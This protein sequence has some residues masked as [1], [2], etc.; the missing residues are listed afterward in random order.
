MNSKGYPLLFFVSI[1]LLSACSSTRHTQKYSQKENQEKK[2]PSNSDLVFIEDISNPQIK[3]H[4]SH[5]IKAYSTPESIIE[6]KKATLFQKKYS[7][8]LELIPKEVLYDPPLW[9]FISEWWGT[10]YRY[11]GTSKRGIDCSAFSQRLYMKVF[12]N[13]LPRTAREQYKDTKK[14]K[15]TKNL[16]PGDLVFFKIHSRHITHVGIY[17]QNDKFIS[18]TSSSGVTISDL[19]SPYWQ[20]YYVGGGRPRTK[21]T[22]NNIM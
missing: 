7:K 3:Q 4:S 19:N 21:D 12:G 8:Y 14:I 16:R 13:S 1:L 9:S 20:R 10:P 5:K 6:A 17:L 15:K 2:P 11:G 22:A 18:A